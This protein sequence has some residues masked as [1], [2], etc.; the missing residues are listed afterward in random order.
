MV[1]TT[2]PFEIPWLLV[3]DVTWPT[4][5]GTVK[6]GV[7]SAIFTDFVPLSGCGPV[8]ADREQLTQVLEPFVS[9]LANPVTEDHAISVVETL[10][11]AAT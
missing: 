8:R 11:G 2:Q 10:E 6:G 9:R 5:D 1:Q 4:I 7:G 3:E